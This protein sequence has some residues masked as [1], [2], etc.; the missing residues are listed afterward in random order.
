M[1]KSEQGWV[2]DVL[3][4]SSAMVGPKPFSEIIQASVL[5]AMCQAENVQSYY[6][7][8]NDC[9]GNLGLNFRASCDA[10][11]KPLRFPQDSELRPCHAVPV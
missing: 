3:R 5:C 10:P 8:V 9:F 2:E 1:E 11:L 4:Y 6:C 7:G